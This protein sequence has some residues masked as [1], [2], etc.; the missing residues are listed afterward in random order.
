MR[1]KKKNSI[2]T[3][4]AES[5]SR[6][7]LKQTNHNLKGELDVL[8]ITINEPKLLIEDPMS[9]TKEVQDE[10]PSEIQILKE[11]IISQREDLSSQDNKIDQLNEKLDELKVESSDSQGKKSQ[12]IISDQSLGVQI[13]NENEELKEKINNLQSQLEKFQSNK[14]KSDWDLDEEVQIEDNAHLVNLKQLNFHLMEENGL[15]RVEV[16][17]LKTGLQSGIE[18]ANSK[19]LELANNKIEDLK[20]EIESLKT[21]LES[22]IGLESSEELK[23]A[24]NKIEALKAEVDDYQAQVKYLQEINESERYTQQT[25]EENIDEFSKLKNELVEYQKQNLVL[26]DMLIDLKEDDE[27]RE[28]DEE[29]Y[30][31]EAYTIPKKI[32]LSLFN[33]IYNLLNT[34]QKRIVKNILILDL[35]SDYLE[36]KRD[37]IKMLSQIKDIEIYNAFIDMIHDKDWIIRLYIIKAL[38]TFENKQDELIVLMKELSTDVDVDVRELAVKVLYNITHN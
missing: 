33:R 26:N 7:E 38:S 25:T 18:L 2:D 16:E 9:F 21:E 1:K 24:T 19:E 31:S 29:I 4:N 15:L 13:T 32:A 28:S 36:V 10:L 22:G 20:A 37:T 34:Q 12:E 8:Q 14:S 23:L 3:V 30:I 27:D 11:I 5:V 6:N 35:A 17:S